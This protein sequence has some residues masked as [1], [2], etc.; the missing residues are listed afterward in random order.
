MNTDTGTNLNDGVM[1][2]GGIGYDVSERDSRRGAATNIQYLLAKEP[3]RET[4]SLSTQEQMS[5]TSQ[6]YA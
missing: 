2:K 6:V 4:C 3:M 1:V 5:H